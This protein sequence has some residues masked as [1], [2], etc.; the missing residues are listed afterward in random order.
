MTCIVGI[1][2]AGKIIMG[3]D[4]AGVAGFSV[5]T[6]T[7]PKVFI[8]EQ[9]IIGFTTSFRMGQILMFAKLPVCNVK[10][11]DDVYKFMVTKFIPAIRKIFS[12]E[13]YLKKSNEV[14]QGGT[15]LVGLKGQLFSICDDFQVGIE[16]YKYASVG[17]GDSIAYGSLHSTE[18]AN[19]ENKIRVETPFV[20]AEERVRI[21]LEAAA[22]FSAGVCPPFLI[23][24]K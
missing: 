17:C 9:Y 19:K 8:N 6:R 18:W 3:G 12:E 15:F 5:V 23:L 10:K 21:A 7:D 24:T 22:T 20:S 14:E 11:P 1:I 2:D 4:S 13:G 16:K